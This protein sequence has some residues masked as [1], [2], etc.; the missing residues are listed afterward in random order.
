MAVGGCFCGKVR[1]NYNGQPL[2]SVS[3]DNPQEST[4]RESNLILFSLGTVPLSRLSQAYRVA[5]YPQL[6]C[7]KCRTGY[8]WKSERSGKDI[9]QWKQYEE[10]FLS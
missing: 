1:I 8:L 4:F 6:C 10:L 9:G 2:K 7:Q 5:L 3:T